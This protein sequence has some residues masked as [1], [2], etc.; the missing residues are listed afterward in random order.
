MRLYRI[1][2]GDR[3]AAADLVIE[4]APKFA[5][6]RSER[7]TPVTIWASMADSKYYRAEALR[8]LDWAASA[9]DP[10]AARRWRRLAEEY[11]VLADQIEAKG[12]GRAPFL[13]VPMQRQPAQQQQGKLGTDE[14][15]DC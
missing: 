1:A 14:T 10:K 8:M 13:A 7:V 12:T 4:L 5:H 3:E 9:A 11:L 6:L 2:P 15:A